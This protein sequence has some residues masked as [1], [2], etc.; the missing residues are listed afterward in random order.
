MTIASM[1]TKILIAISSCFLMVSCTAMQPVHVQLNYAPGKSRSKTMHV[2][3]KK[4]SLRISKIEIFDKRID[5]EHLGSMDAPI[6]GTGVI[7]WVRDGFIS[8]SEFGYSFPPLIEVKTTSGLSLKVNI[9]RAS[10]RG[11]VMHMRCT[12]FIEVDFF[13]DGILIQRKSY[14][15]TQIEDKGLISQGTRHF[16]EKAVLRGLNGAL[17]Q[18]LVKFEADLRKLSNLKVIDSIS[19]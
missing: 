16:G 17:D 15:G 14:Y 11:T 19:Y 5:Q 8:L 13:S 3:G 7:E 18:C 12:L 6:Y 1:K 9:K 2:E 10:C 4:V